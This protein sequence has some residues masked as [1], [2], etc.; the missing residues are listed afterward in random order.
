MPRYKVVSDKE[1][2][3]IIRDWGVVD[4][5]TVEKWGDYEVVGECDDYGNSLLLSDLLNEKEGQSE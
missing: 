5:H 4:T 1:C 3:N 2:S